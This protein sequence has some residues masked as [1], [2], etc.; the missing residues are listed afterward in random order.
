MADYTENA[1][2]KLIEAIERIKESEGKD[3]EANQMLESELLNNAEFIMPVMIAD[4]ESAEDRKLLYGV[5]AMKDGRPFYMLFT[6]KDK[7]KSWNKEGRN[8]KTVT[9]KFE[10]I[11]DLA[12]GDEHIFGLVINPGTDNFIIARAA[13]SDLR[14]RIKGEAMGLQGEKS[15]AEEEVEFRNVREDEVSE[16]LKNSLIMAMRNDP[17]IVKGY[18]RD[19]VRN[20]HLDYVVIIDHTGTMEESFPKIMSICKHHSHDRSVALL[21]AKAPIAAKAIDGVEPIYT[22]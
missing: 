3:R 20:G 22:A 9:H 11:T 14:A 13:I 10:M 17:K 18:F 5:T 15:S 19:M 21:S 1:N 7:L 8:I 6:G 4:E 12:Y 2:T 16:E